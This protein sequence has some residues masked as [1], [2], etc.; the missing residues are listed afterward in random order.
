MSSPSPTIPT[1]S[2]TPPPVAPLGDWNQYTGIV[3]L[4][5]VILLLVERMFSRV[6]K[7]KCLGGEID[8]EDSAPSPPS[9][10]VQAPPSV[11]KD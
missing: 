3:Q 10:S 4:I 8:M 1:L 6:K 2:P 11:K 7:S 5:L 9:P